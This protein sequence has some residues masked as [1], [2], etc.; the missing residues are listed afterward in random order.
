MS[1]SARRIH[2]TFRR[3]K[4]NQAVYRAWQILDE[5]YGDDDRLVDIRLGDIENLTS[6]TMKGRVNFDEMDTFNE[7]IQNFITQVEGI[8][9]TQDLNGRLLVTQIRRKLPEEHCLLFLQK[10]ADG[11]S[12]ESVYGLAKWLNS[13]LILLKTIN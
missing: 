3:E 7:S 12:E 11:K 5:S 4:E 13:H 2:A 9:M 8:Y 6:Y 10:V 1:L